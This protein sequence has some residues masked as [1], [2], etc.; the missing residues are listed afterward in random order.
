MVTG[1]NKV[2][3]QN[4]S[5]QVGIIRQDGQGKIWEAS[6]FMNEL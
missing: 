1:D 4:I 5:E 6:E 3:A 2:T